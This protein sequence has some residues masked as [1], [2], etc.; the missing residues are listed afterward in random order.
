MNLELFYIFA[1]FALCLSFSFNIYLLYHKRQQSLADDKQNFYERL[2]ILKKEILILEKRL[3]IQEK[4]LANLASS[5]VSFE[6]VLTTL[7]TAK[8]SPFGGGFGPDDGTI[9]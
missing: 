1:L 8:S 4:Q 7:L 6:K 5:L 2:S 9:H 3:A